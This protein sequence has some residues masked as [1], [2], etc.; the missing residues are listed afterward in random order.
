LLSVG[1]LEKDYDPLF[2]ITAME[3]VLATSPN[4]GL[5][6]VGDG[7]M[8]NQ[9]EA[10]ISDSGY[11]DK[12]HLAGNVAHAVTLHLINDADVVLRN[13]LFDGDAISVREAIY[14]GTPVIATDNGMRPKGVHLIEIGDEAG[15]VDAVNVIARNGHTKVEPRGSD[16]SNIQAVLAVY[17]ELSSS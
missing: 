13:T 15:F 5:M 16:T 11:G 1:G 3:K 2:Q 6:I 7:S 17:Q 10:S 4:A 14:L 9:V 12:I 8:R